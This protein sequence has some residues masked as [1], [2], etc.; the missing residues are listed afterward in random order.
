MDCCRL[1]LRSV[2]FLMSLKSVS[3][4]YGLREVKNAYCINPSRGIVFKE[5]SLNAVD[6]MLQYSLMKDI[7]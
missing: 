2:K 4:V 6:F 1:F 5:I 3:V 7:T